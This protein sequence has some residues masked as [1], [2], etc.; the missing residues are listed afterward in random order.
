MCE[1]EPN[2]TLLGVAWLAEIIKSL[3]DI[4]STKKKID[5]ENIMYTYYTPIICICPLASFCTVFWFDKPN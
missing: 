2:E 1:I 4:K 5:G 3:P